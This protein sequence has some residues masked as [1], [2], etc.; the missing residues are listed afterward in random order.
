MMMEERK[1][2]E[3]IEEKKQGSST[4]FGKMRETRRRSEGGREGPKVRVYLFFWSR[5][6]F[7]RLL[8]WFLL[9]LLASIS[10]HCYSD[11]FIRTSI[12][13][14]LVSVIL[15]VLLSCLLV[16]CT[17]LCLCLRVCL[18]PASSSSPPEAK[19]VITTTK[20]FSIPLMPY[21]YPVDPNLCAVCVYSL[22]PSSLV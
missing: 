19:N 12:H 21:I 11:L 14:C 17:I 20:T 8:F 1:E 15:L 16:S 6:S 5:D 4:G 10:V 3:K 18:S 7:F 9:L 22:F 13:I 2:S